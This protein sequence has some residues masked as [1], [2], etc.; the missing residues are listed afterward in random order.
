M[1]HHA[2]PRG[3]SPHGS[4][5]RSPASHSSW[6]WVAVRNY[7]AHALSAPR[8]ILCSAQ[9]RFRGP[10]PCACISPGTR[11]ANGLLY[12]GERAG[13]TSPIYSRLIGVGERGGR[14][15]SA[16]RLRAWRKFLSLSADDGSLINYPVPRQP[17]R[18]PSRGGVPARRASPGY[19]RVHYLCQALGATW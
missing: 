6:G 3:P 15:R 16:W 18:F 12:P 17:A 13:E 19:G 5:V 1:T 7:G 14:N 10:P 4:W 8:P 2:P 11:R 9:R